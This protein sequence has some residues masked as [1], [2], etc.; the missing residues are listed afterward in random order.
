MIQPQ[1]SNHQGYSKADSKSG[2]PGRKSE[3]RNIEASD[4]ARSQTSASNFEEIGGSIEEMFLGGDRR[5]MWA[6]TRDRNE[7]VEIREGFKAI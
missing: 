3:N 2:V 5:I 7:I 4:N 1:I 6:V